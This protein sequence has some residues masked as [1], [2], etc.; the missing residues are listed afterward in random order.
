M[1]PLNQPPRGI[2]FVKAHAIFLNYRPKRVNT[3]SDSGSGQGTRVE[4]WQWSLSTSC[5]E[6]DELDF[7]SKFIHPHNYTHFFWASMAHMECEEYEH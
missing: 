4:A 5:V 6:F 2:D 3:T 1:D 7:M